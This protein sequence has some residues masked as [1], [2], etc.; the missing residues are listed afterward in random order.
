M[1]RRSFIALTAVVPFAGC[2]SL[3]GGGIDT[4]IGEDERVE[5]EADEGAELT[6][7][8]D[9][10][11]VHELGDDMDVEREGIG[12]RLDHTEHGILDT[13]SIEGSETFEITV[14][15]GGTHSVVIIGGVATVTIE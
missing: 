3:L 15:N 4:T 7:T 9:V 5:F 14:Q 8:V 12:F 6:V 1:R 2:S 11:E 10:E 13:R